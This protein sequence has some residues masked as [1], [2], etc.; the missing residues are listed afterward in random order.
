MAST[1]SPG[2]YVRH[3][4]RG[5][6]PPRSVNVQVAVRC[7]P[8]NSRERSSGERTVLTCA[9][10]RREVICSAPNAVRKGG[11]AAANPKKMYTYDHVFGPDASQADVYEGIVEPIVDEVLQGYNC[12]VFAYGQTGTGKTHTM[13]GR[14]GADM[15][16]FEERRLAENA[17]IIPRAVKQVFDHLRSITDEHSVR[18]SHLELYNEQLSDLLGPA[19]VVND[20][21]R[22][23]EDPQKG[24]FVQ[25]LE[26]IVVRSEEE[27]FAVL[28]KSAVKRRTAETLM[29]KYSSRSHSVFSITIHIKESTPEGADL[30]KVGKLNLVDLAG[31][32]NVGR[33]GA[34]KGRA[35]EAGNINQSLLTL[36]RVITALVDRHPH[37]PYRDSKLTRLLQESLGGR[38]KTCVIATVTPGSSSAEETAST[39][40]YAYRAKSI[41]N[42]PTVNQMIA[43]HVLLKE[44]TEEIQKLKRELDANRTKN[45]VYLPAD[46]FQRLQAIA[47]QQKDTISQL[48]TRNEDFEKKAAN[49]KEK[50]D[51]TQDALARDQKQLSLTKQELEAVKGELS[52]TQNTLEVVRQ[53]KA[54]NAH[55]VR[56]HVGTEVELHQKGIELQGTLDLCVGDI[57]ALHTRVNAKQELEKENFENLL[58]LQN[59]VARG[60][61]E[62]SDSL[63]AHEETHVSLLQDSETDS[64]VLLEKLNNSLGSM[65]LQLEEFSTRFSKIE[66]VHEDA[67]RELSTKFHS[68]DEE[69]FDSL[70][71]A[72]SQ[73]KARVAETSRNVSD[74][75]A[76][77]KSMLDNTREIM[78]EVQS[79]I[80][81]HSAMEESHRELLSTDILETI[82]DLNSNVSWQV[83]RQAELFGALKIVGEEQAEK[84]A[85]FVKRTRSNLVA[86]VTAVMNEFERE[87]AES[88]R[89]ASAMV[90]SK[91]EDA[92]L[93]SNELKEAI[94]RA[95]E[96]TKTKCDGFFSKCSEGADELKSTVQDKSASLAT[97]C[98][99]A[100]NSASNVQSLLHTLT[101]ETDAAQIIAVESLDGM[102]QQ[103]T[104]FVKE[105]DQKRE[106]DT[107]E[108]SNILS[109]QNRYISHI[110]TTLSDLTSEAH[111][112]TCRKVKAG[113]EQLA[114][115]VTDGKD[116]LTK[117]VGDPVK[118][119]AISC[120]TKHDETPI[121][122]QWPVKET[123]ART[124]NHEELISE[125]R[126]SN[127]S[128]AVPI[129]D[130]G[131]V[132]QQN[133]T[134]NVG[135]LSSNDSSTS[136]ESVD[137]SKQ[138]FPEEIVEDR[139]EQETANPSSAEVDESQEKKQTKMTRSR[140]TA[141]LLRST[142]G[143]SINRSA[144]AEPIGKANRVALKTIVEK[145]EVES[146][147]VLN[148]TTNRRTRL[149]VRR[150]ESMIPKKPS[151]IPSARTRGSTRT[152]A[153][154]V[155]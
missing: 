144:S 127:D 40:D 82:A 76:T 30:L 112:E 59:T 38:N 45:G 77:I 43:K 86:Q 2:G 22:M 33:S 51:R 88:R 97:T 61:A 67:D 1:L 74:S 13:E 56:K 102:A 141:S 90:A 63:Q 133:E 94:V 140:S 142:S 137:F 29:N 42:R 23:Y 48:E 96:T 83:K 154:D 152:R 103:R 36:G 57:R 7:R 134:T 53:Q 44:Y 111:S 87:S 4:Q 125:L 11:S 122:R 99:T 115:F 118:S 98:T 47:N 49:L 55:L 95:S 81:S 65:N 138:V 124:R 106:R 145:E 146:A 17:G 16:G 68:K 150:G 71:K 107:Q 136:A 80:G 32:E 78:G 24:T 72:L 92:E 12:T 60:V 46:E 104:N 66:K 84:Q 41:K 37:V 20:T 91:I 119:H 100:S 126:R 28:D 64:K 70:R 132:V 108:R 50:L 69:V 5:V 6:S 34:V 21:L 135:E 131:H 73:H 147:P 39:L 89:M 26:D 113:R 8:L 123:L 143:A 9:E 101:K 117:T 114:V 14:R 109:E 153:R 75:S 151:G 58:T 121:V 120:D 62:I 85:E 149:R 148:D 128:P 10:E 19:D 54:E 105:A 129:E 155:K 110:G 139:D 79:A 27:I 3:G 93:V 35:R 31:S 25:G 130:F 52:S 18:V 15:V 116:G